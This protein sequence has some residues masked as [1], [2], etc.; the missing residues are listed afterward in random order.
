MFMGENQTKG[1]GTLHKHGMQVE[2]G[3]TRE[4]QAGFSVLLMWDERVRLGDRALG[5][6]QKGP[7][8]SDVLEAAPVT[9]HQ[10]GAQEGTGGMEGCVPLEG[11][12]MTCRQEG[13]QVRKPWGDTSSGV[14]HANQLKIIQSRDLGIP[15][16]SPK[17]P[18]SP[19]NLILFLPV[20]LHLVSL[21][22]LLSS[23]LPLHPAADTELPFRIVH[24][25]YRLGSPQ[26][27]VCPSGEQLSHRLCKSWLHQDALIPRGLPG[28][29]DT[30]RVAESAS[31][32][33]SRTTSCLAPPTLGQG[34][35]PAHGPS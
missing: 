19:P 30:P 24:S 13:A 26:R 28:V 32:E 18:I 27:H 33:S 20:S 35:P 12:R 16:R 4:H 10:G 15:G 3:W 14:S 8:S 21:H 1:P 5:R 2:G 23:Q 25:R 11:S 7:A 31:W 17:P 22:P 9:L 34:L 6:Q 29:S